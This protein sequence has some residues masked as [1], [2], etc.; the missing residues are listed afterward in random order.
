MTNAPD[1]IAGV[2]TS[3]VWA[4]D[5]Q[6]HISAVRSGEARVYTPTGVLVRNIRVEAGQTIHTPLAPGFYIVTPG[7]G[8]RFKVS[9][10]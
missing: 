7:D 10:F 8:S 9:V 4:A 5:G 2:E 3:R 6:L 1:A